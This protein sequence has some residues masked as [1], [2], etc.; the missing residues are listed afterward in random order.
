MVYKKGTLE[1]V[2]MLLSFTQRMSHSGRHIIILGRLFLLVFFL[3]NVGFTA[4]LEHCTMQNESCCGTPAR[5]MACDMSGDV[6]GHLFVNN[7]CHSLKV[8]GG[9]ANNDGT[10]E[11]DTHESTPRYAVVPLMSVVSNPSGVN[12]SSLI[13]PFARKSQPFHDRLGKYLLHEAFLI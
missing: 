4:V 1:M 3:V 12:G 2:Q 10:W 8:V 5:T 6:D 7:G 11:Q 9:R 13:L